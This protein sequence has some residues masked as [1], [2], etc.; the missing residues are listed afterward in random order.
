MYWRLSFA[1]TQARSDEQYR[2][3]ILELIE[4]AIRIRLEPDRPVGVFLSGGTDSSTIVSLA[5]Q[6]SSGPLYT[7]SFRCDGRSYD[8]SRY[9]RFIAERCGTRHSEIPYGPDHLSLISTA[10]K[11]MDEPFCDIGVEIGTYLVG[12]AAQE[13]V[14]Y[15]F[16]GEGGDELFGGHPVYIADKVAALADRLPRVILN[17]LTRTLQRIPDSDQKKNLQVKLKRFAYSLSF[18]PELLSHRW[19]IYYRPQ[20]LRELC[21]ED[22]IHRC[23]M[24]AIFDA[25]LKYNN[26]ADGRDQ[27]SRSL[28]SD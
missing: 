3:E 15:V 23:N 14:S 8:E 1:E 18:P 22:L 27:L 25:I 10:I 13:N 20:E 11:S 6:M 28:Y 2:E 26:E 7:F 16:S 12:Q 5:S 24:D 9:A 4:D 21:A 19:R 17:P